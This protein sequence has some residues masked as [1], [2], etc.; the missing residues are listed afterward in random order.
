LLGTRNATAI[1]SWNDNQ[2]VATVP[3]GSRNG[4]A[5]VGQ[6]GLYSNDIPFTMDVP[7][8]QTAVLR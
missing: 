7:I 2:I 5:E 6:G 8:L 3:A 1:T 4:V